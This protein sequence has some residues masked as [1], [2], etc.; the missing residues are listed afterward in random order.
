MNDQCPSLVPNL[1]VPNVRRKRLC[2]AQRTVVVNQRLQ[3]TVKVVESNQPD[4]HRERRDCVGALHQCRLF[5]KKRYRS[6]VWIRRR[7]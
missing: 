2:T 5:D 3:V 4:L 6:N 1:R 7:S